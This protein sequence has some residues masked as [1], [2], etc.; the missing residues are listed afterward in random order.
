MNTSI[1]TNKESIQFYK[2]LCQK[3]GC[4]KVVKARR[5]KYTICDIAFHCQCPMISS[6]SKGEG[7]DLKGSDLDV[8]LIH[9]DFIVYETEPDALKRNKIYLVMETKDT[10]PCFTYLRLISPYNVL[11]ISDRESFQKN[12]T[13]NLFSSELYKFN[14]LKL[15]TKYVP[16]LNKTHGPC[17]ADA[18]DDFDFAFCLKC[19]QWISAAYPWI[20]RAR[21][22]WPSSEL[23]SKIIT[24]GVLFVP[25]GIKQSKNEGI[26]WRI[27]F[28]IAEKMLIYSFTHTQL[29]CYSLLKILLKEIVENCKNLKGLLCSYFLKTLVFW[30]SEELDPSV[31]RPDNII[32]CYQSCLERLIYCIEYSTLLHYF[33]PENNLFYSRFSKE[34]REQ[35]IKILRISYALGIRCFSVSSTLCD[36]T[37]CIFSPLSRNAKV[38]TEMVE[39]VSFMVSISKL[40]FN[41]LHHSR[42]D[43]SRDIFTVFLS[44]AHQF[45]PQS[46]IGSRCISNKHQYNTYKHDISHL[47]IGL[48]SDAVSGWLFLASFFYR[49]KNYIASLHVINYALLKC[50]DDKIPVKVQ[51]GFKIELNRTQ[52]N[53]LE[54]MQQEKLFKILKT[55]QINDLDF[56]EKSEIIP[57]EL[58][59][60][61]EERSTIIPAIPFAHFLSFLCYFHSCDL[62]SALVS[63]Q[64]IMHIMNTNFTKDDF[65]SFYVFAYPIILLGICW[66]M[67]RKTSMARRSF[68][69]IAISDKYKLT[70]AAIRL[71]RI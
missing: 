39:N 28:S 17:V 23:V 52:Y 14:E 3:I 67:T 66:Q 42:T 50:T 24:C 64:Q 20:T 6:G 56:I 12:G 48:S 5:L 21:V 13:Q 44:R 1:Y 33:I 36:Y 22:R 60:E 26:E 46:Q 30:I 25:I 34:D 4:E 35:L 7:L 51:P 45:A 58:Q 11:S 29:L 53:V 8:M 15:A 16:Y 61:V 68:E 62:N 63:M 40:L 31:W 43:L 37:K 55:V 27:S 49:R 71:S 41:L 47:L 59:L 10:P 57:E 9:P 18:N 19:D 69:L 38:M 54:S 65:E 70:S 32:P 2:Y